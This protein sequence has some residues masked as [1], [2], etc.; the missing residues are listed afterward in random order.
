MADPVIFDD[1]GSTRI[2]RVMPGG[3]IGAMDGLIDVVTPAP[4]P[5][6]P[7]TSGSH[8][9]VNQPF[10]DVMIV[11]QDATGNAF[12][13][14]NQPF[15]TVEV[16]SS[17]NQTVLGDLVAANHLRITVFG[18]NDPLVDAKQHHGKRRYI[19]SNAGP[20]QQIFVDG[21]QV[22]DAGAPPLGALAP[23]LY[24]SVILT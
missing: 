14:P 1:G 2:K 5:A 13:I 16:R 20:I 17:L 4:A 12:T 7:G 10:S 3:G 22:L 21:V 24:T 15:N 18:P 6:P 9:T 8:H 19:V 23:L 11:F